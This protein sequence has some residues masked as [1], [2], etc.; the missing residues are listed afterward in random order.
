MLRQTILN[1]R[2]EIWKACIIKMDI[3]FKIEQAKNNIVKYKN[4]NLSEIIIDHEKIILNSLKI[5]NNK[6][7]HR[8]KILMQS[9]EKKIL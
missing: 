9:Y 1:L 2:K 5:D 3:V 6:Y 7:H 4:S 8:L